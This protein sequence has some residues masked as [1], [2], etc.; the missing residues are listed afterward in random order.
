[1]KAFFKKRFALTDQGATDLV[2]SSVITFFTYFINMLPVIVLMLFFD[3]VL[4]MNER[5]HSIYY[6]A[7]AAALGLIFMFLSMEYNA[8]YNSTYKES[9]KLRIDIARNISNLPLSYFS[10]HDLS[11]L[12]QTIMADVTAI[13]HALSHA[14]AKAIGFVAFFVVISVLL[15]SGNVILG[16]CIICPI[17][18]YFLLIFLS[19]RIQVNGFDRYYQ[20]LRKNSD[21]FQEAIEL[22]M[23]IQSFGMS[24]DVKNKLNK[25]VE[26]GEK[27][28]IRSE[29]VGATILNLASLV[30]YV[31]HVLVIIVGTTFLAKGDINLLYFLGYLLAAIKIKEGAEAVSMNVMELFYLDSM[32]KRVNEIRMANRQMGEDK[33]LSQ[34]DIELKNVSFSYDGETSVLDDISFVAKQ[35]EVTALVGKSGCGKT[36]ILKLVSRLY[37]TT[38]GAILI[39]G[40]DIKNISTKSLFDKVSIVFQDVTLFN[41]SV[42]ENIRI[43]NVNA[44]DEEVKNAARLANCEEFIEKMENGYDTLIGENGANLSGGE[45]QRLSIARAFLKDAPIILLDEIAAS[46]DVDNEKKIQDSLNKL[47]KNKTVLIISHRLKSVQNVDKIVVIDNGKVEAMGKHDELL[48]KSEIY[49]DLIDKTLLAEQFV[50]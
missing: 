2:K 17:L 19:K 50:Y 43:G 39:S 22:Q 15:L 40:E 48:E 26:E 8:L 28:H 12:A 49:K 36:S 33:E 29:F 41:A 21:S 13:E 4:L 30:L 23:E 20:K 1:M 11:D 10:K 31:A 9:E 34:F 44:T 25:E 14:I 18:A 27:I 5:S 47:T 7:C 46:L 37:D 45:R 24:E 3:Y 6:I 38:G 32:I 42:L 16:L 35:N